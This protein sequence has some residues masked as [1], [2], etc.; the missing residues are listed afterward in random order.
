MRAMATF[1]DLRP[2][3]DS[4]G[5]EFRFVSAS[6]SPPDGAA[7]DRAARALGVALPDEYRGFLAELGCVYFDVAE[8]TWPRPRALEIRPAWQMC[9]GLW[10]HGIAEHPDL[11][12]IAQQARAKELG[13]DVVPVL[14][15]AGM[16][17]EGVGYDRA[18]RL[19]RWAAGEETT[20]LDGTLAD[21][22]LAAM[23]RLAADRER[24][25]AEPIAPNDDEAP[26]LR[27]TLTLEVKIDPPA[28]VDALDAALAEIA[29]AHPA[30]W[31]AAV[32]ASFAHD[33]DDAI[34]HVDV[35]GRGFDVCAAS[36]LAEHLLPKVFL[37][38]IRDPREDAVA[39]LV[40]AAFERAIA[41]RGRLA[42]RS[43]NY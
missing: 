22:V 5:D 16:S 4:T 39:A 26:A 12:V 29:V 6:A 11:D 41:A 37:Q 1:A 31:D 40:L 9:F 8:D 36:P 32:V 25:R 24:L 34:L 17:R 23:R 30:R 33:L 35:D 18:G 14:R 13:V 28:L 15:V 38:S 20:P 27:S 19:V 7:I 3:L 10:V 2:F 21:H 43:T 42:D